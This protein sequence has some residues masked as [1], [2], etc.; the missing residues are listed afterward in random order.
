MITQI[1]HIK[2]KV[3]DLLTKHPH[4]RDDD[5]KLIATIW[6]KETGVDEK[7]VF[8]SQQTTAFDFFEAFSAG[9]YTNPE[10]VRR[11]RQKVQEQN[12]ELRGNA[13]KNRKEIGEEFKNEI[14][15]V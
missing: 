5:N 15:S 4:L 7:N 13:Y 1:K 6:N 3:I 11:C 2:N 9:Q 8:I 10:S 12:P 14:F